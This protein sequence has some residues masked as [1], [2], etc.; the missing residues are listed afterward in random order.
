MKKIIIAICL[1]WLAGL[2]Q[3]EL[4]VDPK[5]LANPEVLG[6]SKIRLA[7]LD[8]NLA[9]YVAQDQLAGGVALVAKQG[10][11][12]YLN[13]F[14]QQDK[15]QQ[16]AMQTDSL[17]RIAS[18]TKAIVSVAI[19]MLQEEGKLLLSDKVSQY[20]PAFAHMQ[21]RVKDADGQ[22]SLQKAKRQITIR[23]L[24]THTSGMGY[25]WG[26]YAHQ[27]QQAGFTEWYFA[28][29]NQPMAVWVNKIAQQPLEAQPGERFVYGFNTD[30]LGVIIEK[31]SGLTL[32]DFLA[33]KIFQPLAMHDTYFFVPANKQA[34][35]ATVYSA[36][37][38]G[39]G[40]ITRAPQQGFNVSQGHY[41][42]NPGI[43]ES[44]GAGLV[45]TALDYAKFLQMLLN[46]G[47]YGEQHILSPSS[48][49]LM[50]TN[51]LGDIKLDWLPGVGFGLGFTVV[52]DLGLRGVPGAVGEF[53]W[54]GAYHSTYWV[55]PKNDL[56]VVYLT[57]L[58][59]AGDIDDHAKLRALVYQ[60]LL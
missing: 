3:A 9:Q 11:V 49:A 38:T 2:T 14:G 29:K 32:G 47:R 5:I 35:L 26:E 56:L 54:G 48:V 8:A 37:G 53:G 22:V 15:E 20:L 41:L 25:G 12:V 1:Y 40:K 44:G 10:K 17:F 33:Q 31:I 34:R 58:I 23:D 7:R 43:A 59:P 50:T 60:A 39:N 52:N 28:D 45:S 27:W 24:L 46:Q 21:V 13:A 18:Q 57:Q 16:V 19:M 30:I 6:V 4:Q 55:D 42:G 36:N 51:H